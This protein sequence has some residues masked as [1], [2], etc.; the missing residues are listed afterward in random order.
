MTSEHYVVLGAARP[1]AA[2]FADVGRWATS[3]A[4]PVE[5]VR[6]VSADEVRARLAAGRSW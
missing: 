5:F 2:W 4:L 3:A 1:R 6:C